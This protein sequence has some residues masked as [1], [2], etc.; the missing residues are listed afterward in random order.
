MYP[1][2]ASLKRFTDLLRNETAYVTYK[3]VYFK[4]ESIDAS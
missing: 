4:V 1:S 2:G 3:R